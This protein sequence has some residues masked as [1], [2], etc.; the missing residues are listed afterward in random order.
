LGVDTVETSSIETLLP[1]LLGNATITGCADCAEPAGESRALIALSGATHRCD[2]AAS[3]HHAPFLAHLV[4]TNDKHPQS[5][6]RR[7]A[8]PDMAIIGYRATAA[9]QRV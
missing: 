7:R 4:A 9:L 8:E 6:E 1:C 5:R 2:R 3:F